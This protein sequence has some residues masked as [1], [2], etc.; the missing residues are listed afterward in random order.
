MIL[1]NQSQPIRRIYK[2]FKQDHLKSGEQKMISTDVK[3]NK[4]GNRRASKM[5]VELSI[6][7]IGMIA[8]MLAQIASHQ[9]TKANNLQSST[10]SNVVYRLTDDI[11]DKVASLTEVSPMATQVNWLNILF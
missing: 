5:L 8:V 10:N 9:S 3:V 11:A 2:M 7:I 1:T 6:G 4:M